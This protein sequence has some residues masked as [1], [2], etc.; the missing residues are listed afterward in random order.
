MRG[1][2]SN[3]SSLVTPKPDLGLAMRVDV[4]GLDRHVGAMA[5]HA[6]DH[7]QMTR[8]LHRHSGPPP[9]E[10]PRRHIDEQV[11]RQAHRAHR[12]QLGNLSQHR[13]Q[14]DVARL[15][16]DRGQLR[17]AIRLP[18]FLATVERDQL[19]QPRPHH[20]GQ[21]PDHPGDQQLFATVQRRADDPVDPPS[22]R[23]LDPLGQQPGQ[24]LLADLLAPAFGLRDVR[25]Q[26][27]GE[28]VGIGDA[29]LPEPQRLPGSIEDYPFGDGV[30][31]FNVGG[32]M[33]ALVSL[34][35]EPAS[36]NPQNVIR[37][38]RLRCAPSTPRFVPATT[39]T[40]ATGTPWNS[41]VQIEDDEL[42]EMIDHSYEL[43]V[44]QLTRRHR[45]LLFGS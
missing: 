21:S 18:E 22:G 11:S 17:R 37:S 6:I 14:A 8:S 10:D 16:P 42:R 25:D 26:P 36:V 24:K 40:N 2:R 32:R 28:L 23:R 35:G 39:R 43:V 13:V 30:A 34:D 19:P 20:R 41:T 7:P 33:F 9:G 4:V 3:P 27:L 29:A 15:G 1:S 5:D 45:D 38:L 31:V 12:L 44:R